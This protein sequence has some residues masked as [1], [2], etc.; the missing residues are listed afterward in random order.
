M[1]GRKIRQLLSF[2]LASLGSL[3]C[4]TGSSNFT[5][6]G[7][8]TWSP[9]VTKS[10]RLPCALSELALAEGVSLRDMARE[11]AIAEYKAQH[12]AWEPSSYDQLINYIIVVSEEAKELTQQIID[13]KLPGESHTQETL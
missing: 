5:R 8:S 7:A 4:R 13:G 9:A 11:K 3:M 12:P 1:V 10:V 2:R 6:I